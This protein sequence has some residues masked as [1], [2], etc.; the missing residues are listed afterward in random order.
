VWRGRSQRATQLRILCDLDAAVAR[1]HPIECITGVPPST[2]RQP[3]S[4]LRAAT[5]DTSQSSTAS[6]ER[7]RRARRTGNRVVVVSADPV[8]RGAHDAPRGPHL[9]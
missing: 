9:R 6:S 2:V 8:L 1:R 3:T 4:G 5:S 7:R